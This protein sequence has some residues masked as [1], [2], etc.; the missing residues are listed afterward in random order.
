MDFVDQV[1][2]L[3]AKVP[4]L[5][6]FIKTEAATR[7][8]LVEPFIRALGYDTSDPTE[9]VPEFGANLN[10]PGVPKDKKV[11]Y[12]I[13]K[14]GKPIILIECKCHTDK[15]NEGYKQ[16]FHYAVA[17][18][19]RIGILT[20]GLVYRFYADLDKP[21]KLDDKPF[22]E[23]DLEALKEPLLEELRCLAK[24][25]FDI[26]GMLTAAMEL[27]YIGGILQI[28]TEQFA[29]P[30]DDFV[31]FFY[32]KVCEGKSFAGSA[33][34]QFASYTTRAMGQFVRDRINNLLDGLNAN[35]TNPQPQPQPQPQQ[36]ESSVEEGEAKSQIVT[37]EEELEGFYVV[38]SILR[39]V[40]AADRIVYRDV[41]SYFGILL[42]NNNRKPICRLYF[43]SSQNKKLGLFDISENGKQEE[44]VSIERIDD[45]Y[46]YASQLKSTVLKYV[47]SVE[48]A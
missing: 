15:L 22:L 32:Q 2:I 4:G 26:D 17:T 13:F 48:V 12:A 34:Q 36:I 5:L 9:V 45:I 30:S 18:D 11:D 10:V 21:N 47:E 44:R 40:V 25:S 35:G 38:K 39:E 41:A 24:P 7:S 37:T 1:K 8:S 16:L 23:L 20:N 28:L 46:Q 29:S 27:K 31:K 42:D 33:K 43:N 6:D 3:S 14:D 19:C